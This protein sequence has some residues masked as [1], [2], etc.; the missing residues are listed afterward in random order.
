LLYVLRR[1]F[2]F[3]TRRRPQVKGRNEKRWKASRL[4]VPMEVVFSSVRARLGTVKHPQRSKYEKI[5]FPYENP[6]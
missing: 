6:F 3:I 1:E 4:Q 5:C 2:F